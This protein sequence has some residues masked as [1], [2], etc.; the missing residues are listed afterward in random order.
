MKKKFLNLGIQP[1]ANSFLSSNSKKTLAK[2]FF[3]NLE[4]SFDT[5]SYLV[6]ISN[7]VNPKL[8][9]LMTSSLQASKI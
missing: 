4:V 2:E 9:F 8:K 1:L 5:N 6:S 3:Y 7:P